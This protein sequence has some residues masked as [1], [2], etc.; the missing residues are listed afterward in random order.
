MYN[1][2]FNK[3]NC[4]LLLAVCSSPPHPGESCCMPIYLRLHI[5]LSSQQT[6]T[7]YDIMTQRWIQMLISVP[8][9]RLSSCTPC[10]CGHSF[11]RDSESGL[12]RCWSRRKGLKR[13]YRWGKK[14]VRSC[15]SPIRTTSESSPCVEMTCW[16]R[17]CAA[18]APLHFVSPLTSGCCCCCRQL[19]NT[20]LFI[21][22]SSSPHSC[23]HSMFKF[24]M[25]V[26]CNSRAM[27]THQYANRISIT[28]LWEENDIIR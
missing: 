27:I 2:C 7:L 24:G 11:T 23:F 10:T 1:T 18:P 22:S 16:S 13:V 28:V 12:Q 20:A 19:M 17:S 4:R 8:S 21:W 5:C 3:D 26:V 9:F 25:N 15:C 6:L 14:S